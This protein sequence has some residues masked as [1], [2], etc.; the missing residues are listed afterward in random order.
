MAARSSLLTLTYT[1]PS[2]A[3]LLMELPSAVEVGTVLGEQMHV[4]GALHGHVGL[5]VG[6]DDGKPVAGHAELDEI[7]G[8]R[9]G[10][11]RS[12]RVDAGGIEDATWS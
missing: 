5:K 12:A 10:L 7:R 2:L 3:L 1:R 9:K 6:G 4:S 8:P 11:L